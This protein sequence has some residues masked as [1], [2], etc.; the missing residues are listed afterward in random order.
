MT[1]DK[2]QLNQ[3]PAVKWETNVYTK[4]LQIDKDHPLTS[5]VTVTIT[6]V[7]KS[8]ASLPT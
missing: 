8:S 1:V 5:T 2:V 6:S 7:D 4:P 3:Q